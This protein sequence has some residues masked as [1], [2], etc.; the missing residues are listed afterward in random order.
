MCLGPCT[1][2]CYSTRSACSGTSDVKHRMPSRQRA[3][4][5][6]QI[7]HWDTYTAN[8][9]M[10]LGSLCVVKTSDINCARQPE[11][12]TTVQVDCVM[13]VVCVS[14]QVAC[15]F[16]ADEEVRAQ[17]TLRS[18]SK[19]LLLASLEHKCNATSLQATFQGHLDGDHMGCNVGPGGVA[20]GSHTLHQ[21]LISSSTCS[22]HRQA[23]WLDAV[24]R[25]RQV[26]S[27]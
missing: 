17:D 3:P 5:C 20:R 13:Q 23:A 7:Q 24:A 12:C 6:C 19:P 15:L 8:G 9:R 26:V 11:L 25:G 1:R 4:C 14:T 10:C 27:C 16:S 2:F 21:G 18:G 22:M